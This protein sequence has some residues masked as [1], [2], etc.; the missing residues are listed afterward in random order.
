MAMVASDSNRIV[1]R[2]WKQV[3]MDDS[4]ARHMVNA[5]LNVDEWS[6]R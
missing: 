6:T 5:D 1:R 2:R 3:G 4:A